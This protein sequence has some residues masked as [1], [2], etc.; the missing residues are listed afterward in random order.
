VCS[1]SSSCH[2]EWRIL[3][4]AIGAELVL[5]GET[6]VQQQQQLLQIKR[7][8]SFV[9]V[10]RK[11]GAHTLIELAAA[12]CLKASTSSIVVDT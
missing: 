2:F 7:M 9:G 5:T 10:R 12:A 4:Q 6:T 3:L 11:A 8:H 1:S